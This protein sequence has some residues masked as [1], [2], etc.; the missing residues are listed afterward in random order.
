MGV[1][2]AQI[3]R[4]VSGNVTSV[5]PYLMRASNTHKSS[6]SFET[7]FNSYR[8]GFAGFKSLD[9]G[10]PLTKKAIEQGAVQVGLVFS[11]DGGVEATGFGVVGA[12][13]AAGVTAFS[14]STIDAP[15]T[16]AEDAGGTG[17][18]TRART[19][20][21]VGSAPAAAE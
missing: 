16:G 11:S 2:S 19:G 21:V 17:A 15:F 9:A 3:I 12:T 13:G 6:A 4:S 8:S 7:F 10:G 18:G 20:S 1:S 5:W 14:V